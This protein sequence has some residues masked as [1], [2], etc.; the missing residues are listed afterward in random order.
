MVIMSK[1]RL[2][3]VVF[4]KQKTAYEIDNE[5]ILDEINKDKKQ[6]GIKSKANKLKKI[7]KVV[8]FFKQKT[9]YEMYNVK[10]E[11]DEE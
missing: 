5:S 4:F 2:L 11:E 8:V 10:T 7:L 3:I 6:N 9:A 1:Y